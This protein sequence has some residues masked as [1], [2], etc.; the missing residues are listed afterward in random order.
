MD[1][2]PPLEES[3]TGGKEASGGDA[4]MEAI[5]SKLMGLNV[6]AIGIHLVFLPLP[7]GGAR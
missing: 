6:T 1:Y 4:E 3:S 5:L 7:N 2:K